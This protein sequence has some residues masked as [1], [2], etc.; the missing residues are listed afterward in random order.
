LQESPQLVVGL[1]VGYSATRRTSGFLVARLV[2]SRLLAVE[3]PYAL[4]QSDAVLA[5]ES[6]L[7]EHAVAAVAVDAPIAGRRPRRYR[8][9]ERVFSLGRFQKLC[10]PGSSGSLVG[11]SLAMACETNLRAVAAAATYVPFDR[12]SA[13]LGEVPVVEAFPTAAM[14]VLSAPSSLPMA[15][16]SN[17]TDAYFESLMAGSSAPVGGIEITDDLRTVTNHEARMAVV[18]ALVASWYLS[19]A[20]CAVGNAPEGYFLMPA[21]SAWHPEWRV[22]LRSSLNRE[23]GA[24]CFSGPETPPYVDP[25]ELQPAPRDEPAIRSKQLAAQHIRDVASPGCASRASAGTRA[26]RGATVQVGYVNRNHQEVVRATGRPGTDHGQTVY[27]LRCELCKTQY[28]SNG[29]DNFQ[30]KCPECQGGAPGLRV[31]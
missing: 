15:S 6:A 20:Y 9:V 18:C 25:P 11:R 21:T 26:G 16:R 23:E 5:L 13:P 10:K 31:S 19:G 2:G 29:S 12:L 30:R 17:K 4:T 7:R 28:G 27:V 24:S 1:D 22:E 3:G 8:A 14:A